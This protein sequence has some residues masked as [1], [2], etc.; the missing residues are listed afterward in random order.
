M[1]PIQR[2]L[3]FGHPRPA[4]GRG[5]QRLARWR[6]VF[7]EDLDAQ[8]LLRRAKGPARRLAPQAPLSGRRGVALDL[9][10]L[11]EG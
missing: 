7:A 9:E 8:P 11:G 2:G 1:P 6:G 4:I 10:G 3:V 5:G